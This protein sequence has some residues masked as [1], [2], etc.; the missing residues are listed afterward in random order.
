ML[1]RLTLL[2]FQAVCR[3][4]DAG[5]RHAEIA[6]DLDLSVSTIARIADDRR[7]ARDEP[8]EGEMPED[9][10][11]PDYSAQQLRRCPGCGA[12]VYLWPCLACQ[13]ATAVPQ[14]EQTFLSAEK[15]K[16]HERINRTPTSTFR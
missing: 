14:V 16:H 12:M 7:L 2:Q 8:T 15:K 9:D 1:G 11:P 4:L 13:P 3:A 5:S 10:P 6:R